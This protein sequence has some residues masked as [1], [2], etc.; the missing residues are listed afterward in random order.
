MS[1]NVK[2]SHGMA[3]SCHAMP[4][5]VESSRV[6][7]SRV[8]LARAHLLLARTHLIP[9]RDAG[10]RAIAALCDVI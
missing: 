3:M 10:E 4:N 1:S 7:S 2:S 5:R 8:F 6:K 9:I